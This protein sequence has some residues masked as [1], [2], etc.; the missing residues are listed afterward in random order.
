MAEQTFD[1]AMQTARRLVAE[2][3]LAEAE[4]LYR[5]ILTAVG[6][7][8]LVLNALGAVLGQAGKLQ[9]AGEVLT[10]A[11][12]ADPNFADAWANLANVAEQTNN[13]D[14]AMVA[15]RRAIELRAGVGSYHRRLGVCLGRKGDLPA[16]I[17]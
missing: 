1:Q 3:K 16:A 9:Q 2:G 11:T 15:L 5:R 14:A 7:H 8:P 12:R 17:T 10:R 6:D 13:P 4:A